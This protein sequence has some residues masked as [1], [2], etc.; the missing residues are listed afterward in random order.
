MSGSKSGGL[1]GGAR[2]GIVVGI[3][4][5][6]VVIVVVMAACAV[7]V[8]GY[9]RPTSRVGLFMIEVRERLWAEEAVVLPASCVVLVWLNLYTL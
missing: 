8:Y 2:G 9:R 5:I 3:L 6:L 4:V 1:S 7:L